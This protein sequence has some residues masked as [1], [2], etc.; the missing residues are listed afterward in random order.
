[1]GGDQFDPS[2]RIECR[3]LAWGGFDRSSQHLNDGGV[4]CGCHET[5]AHG[6][7][8]ARKDALSWAAARLVTGPTAE[9][10]DRDRQRPLERRRGAR[11]RRV[12]PGWGQVVPSR[13]G[14]EPYHSRRAVWRVPGLA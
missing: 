2:V 7:G 1:M 10:L 4:Y 11:G 14:N 8:N 5:S 3:G 13:W 9:V 12:I 6:L